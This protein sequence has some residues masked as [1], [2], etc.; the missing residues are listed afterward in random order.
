MIW[1]AE[2]QKQ[3]QKLEQRGSNK[4]KIYVFQKLVCNVTAASKVKTR[5]MKEG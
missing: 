2:N 1:Q 4:L 5:L 3:K